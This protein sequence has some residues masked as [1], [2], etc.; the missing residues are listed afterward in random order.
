LFVSMIT[1]K[2]LNRLS[3]NGGKVANEHTIN[4]LDFGGNV[5][6]VTLG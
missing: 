5:D 6:L 3:K 4:K 1:Q 2:L